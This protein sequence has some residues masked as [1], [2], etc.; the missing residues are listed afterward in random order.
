MLT[1]CPACNTDD[2]H[3]GLS[4]FSCRR[5]PEIWPITGGPRSRMKAHPAGDSDAA[6]DAE[7]P[8]KRSHA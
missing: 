7:Q 1:L 3:V 5:C 2:V 8:K 4:H 6:N